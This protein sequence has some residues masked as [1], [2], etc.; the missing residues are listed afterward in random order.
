MGDMNRMAI[1]GAAGNIEAGLQTVDASHKGAVVCHPHPL[2]GGSMYDAVVEHLC[3]GFGAADVSSL[4]FNFR[5]VGGSEGSHDRGE[6]ESQDVIAVCDWYR[7]KHGLQA[8]YLAGYSFGAGIA[9]RV[10]PYVDCQAIVVVAPPLGMLD[11]IVMTD[12]PVLVMLGERDNIVDCGAAQE[13]FA[14]YPN[15][16]ASVI[17]GADHFFM[18][19]GDQVAIRVT[20]FVSGT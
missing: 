19:S 8:L 17:A 12:K 3:D 15:V 4:R 6:G 18:T 9:L 2:Y 14:D 5:G 10:A 7:R 1:P 13:F 20:E 11:K 16:L